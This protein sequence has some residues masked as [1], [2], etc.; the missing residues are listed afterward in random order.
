MYTCTHGL[1]YVCLTYEAVATSFQQ[2]LRGSG[3][4][5]RPATVPI[6]IH[7]GTIPAPRR[8]W[9]R[10]VCSR[11]YGLYIY[12]K[13]TSHVI[14]TKVRS[15]TPSR[16]FF[17]FFGESADPPSPPARASCPIDAIAVELLACNSTVSVIQPLKL[18]TDARCREWVF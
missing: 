5:I 17:T 13:Y 2:N 4:P 3:D 9:Y 1:L 10:V 12:F 7:L 11:Q 8:Y 6:P 14:L 15:K 16:I 18:C